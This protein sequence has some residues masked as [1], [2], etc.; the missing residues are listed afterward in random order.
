M[1]PP[2]E[3]G[4]PVIPRASHRRVLAGFQAALDLLNQGIEANLERIQL[5][6]S[7]VTACQDRV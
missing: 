6:L 1:F 5:I 3:V 7:N 2:A 4:H